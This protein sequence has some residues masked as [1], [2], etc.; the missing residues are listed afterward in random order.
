MPLIEVN[1]LLPKL[2]IVYIAK[3]TLK[4]ESEA[5]TKAFLN[6]SIYFLI[7]SIFTYL[8][9]ALIDSKNC[10]LVKRKFQRDC[11]L[12]GLAQ[13]TAIFCIKRLMKVLTKGLSL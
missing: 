5:L 3:V 6:C 12:Q 8:N 13:L 9:L 2:V 1:W 4:V 11:Y 10:I 7:Q